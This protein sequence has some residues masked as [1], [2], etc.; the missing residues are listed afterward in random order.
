VSRVIAA[1]I[2]T[3]YDEKGIIWPKEVAPFDVEI[4]PLAGAEADQQIISLTEEYVRVLEDKGLE[5]LVDDRSESPGR[6]FNDADLIGIPLRVTIGQRNLKN[7][8]VEIKRR[9]GNEVILVKTDELIA[10]VLE[11]AKNV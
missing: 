10:R 6:K 5:V 1:I 4:L 8:Q 11:L 7:G 2:E 3:H 9:L